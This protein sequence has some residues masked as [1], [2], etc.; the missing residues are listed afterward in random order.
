VD[1]ADPD[2]DPTF[3]FDDYPDQDTHIWKINN[4]FGTF[5]HNNA[6]SVCFYLP[7]QQAS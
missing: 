5:I 4:F 2:P 3:H 7:R 1:D 6:S